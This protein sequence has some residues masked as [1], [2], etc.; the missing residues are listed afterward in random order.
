MSRR[1]WKMLALVA[2]VLYL[3]LKAWCGESASSFDADL[4]INRPWIDRMP[5]D[6]KDAVNAMALSDQDYGA[7]AFASAFHWN[8][9]IVRWNAKRDTLS[10]HYL[11]SE[12]KVS[13]QMRVWKCGKDAPQPFELCL[14]LEGDGK[15]LRYFSREDWRVRDLPKDAPRVLSSVELR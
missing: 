14:S 10:L 1:R 6:E 15:K 7:V 13:Y 2:V 3:V 11:Q 8:V 4:L 9:D 12:K 5:S